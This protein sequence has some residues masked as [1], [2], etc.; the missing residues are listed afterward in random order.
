MLLGFWCVLAMLGDDQRLPVCPGILAAPN[1]AALK[2]LVDRSINYVPQA[3]AEVRPF[4][5][6]QV[7]GPEPFGQRSLQKVR[8]L[9][10]MFADYGC[11]TQ[12]LVVLAYSAVSS[13]MTVAPASNQWQVAMSGPAEF[14]KAVPAEARPALDAAS[15]LLLFGHGS[16]GNACSLDVGAFQDVKMDGKV[17]MCGDCFSAAAPGNSGKSAS[18]EGRDATLPPPEGESFAMRAVENGAVVV[19][20]HMA[21]NAGFPH[22]FPVLEG[23]MDGL[24]VGEA[25]QRLVNALMGFH[26]FT[27]A[28]LS[29]PDAANLNSLLYVVIGDPAFQPLAKMTPHTPLR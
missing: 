29:S 5:I 4:V 1:S 8:M 18:S 13:G 10:S 22:L 15:L 2:S 27:V 20:A 3:Q 19:Y 23:W 17:V 6:G 28:D 25:Y 14:V 12:S 24:P 11:T 21:E 26:H 9:R 16:R 7:L